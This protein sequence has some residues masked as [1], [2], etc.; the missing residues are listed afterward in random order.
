MVTSGA[1]RHGQQIADARRTGGGPS[2]GGATAVY[3]PRPS[4]MRNS[5]WYVT[6]RD[7]RACPP[8]R[9]DGSARAPGTPEQVAAQ[10]P[11]ATYIFPI[12]NTRA[13]P[14]KTAPTIRKCAALATTTSTPAR[15]RTVSVPAV[16]AAAASSD[17]HAPCPPRRAARPPAARRIP[18]AAR[19]RCAR[20]SAPGRAG[21]QQD[22]QRLGVGQDRGDAGGH[23][24]PVGAVI[25]R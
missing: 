24:G 14:V 6:R 18:P 17:N 10:H 7:H 12:F 21:R 23:A 3:V 11:T 2:P 5:S 9:V 20:R 4:T 13:P 1:R 19:C 22:Q 25:G 15:R 8:C 16:T